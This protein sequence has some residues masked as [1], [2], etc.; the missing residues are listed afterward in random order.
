MYHYQWRVGSWKDRYAVLLISVKAMG[1]CGNGTL[2][3][4]FFSILHMF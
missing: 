3:D 4:D 1:H 2:T